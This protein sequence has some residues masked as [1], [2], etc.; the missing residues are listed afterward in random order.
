MTTKILRYNHKTK[1]VEEFDKD[2]VPASGDM[3]FL[4]NNQWSTGLTSASCACHS[5][6]VQDFREDIE[7]AGIRGVEVLNDGRVKFYSRKA[8]SDYMRMRG[9]F[10]RDAGYG[11][12]A[13]NSF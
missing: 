8:R 10:D 12:A 4:G 11:D 1:K 7:R 5:E 3:L 6:Q 2:K 9:L 13:P